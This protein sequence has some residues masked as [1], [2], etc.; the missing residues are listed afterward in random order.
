MKQDS[1]LALQKEND[2]KDNACIDV[3][4]ADTAP[5]EAALGALLADADAD[6]PAADA[7][8]RVRR[9]AERLAQLD[10][11]NVAGMLAAASEGGG[12]GER[13]AVR[14]DA[15]LG[16]AAALAT[17]RTRAARALRA[18]GA[19]DPDA[20]GDPHRTHAD[21]AARRLL[22][23]LRDLLDWL[24][25][26]PLRDLD[27]LGELSLASEEGRARAL[28]VA[29]ALRAALRRAEREP[30]ARR[31]A[32]VRERLRRL[33]RAR[34]QLAAALARHLNNALVH[35]GNEAQAG[36]GRPAAPRRHHAE[37]LPYAPFM[38]WLKDMDSRAFD[39]LGKLYTGTWA[40]VYER[41]VRAASD[42]ARADLAQAPPD[43]VDAIFDGVLGLVETIC[44]AEQEFCT[45][46]FHLDVDVKVSGRSLQLLKFILKLI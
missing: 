38:R 31:L 29:A 15:A 35:L 40:R 25:A 42:A 34:D 17:R 13:L 23:H 46:F 9:L 1:T 30:A 27:A 7:E 32:A 6:E 36:S 41:E 33:A 14:L 16:A 5:S 18:A 12:R 19:A 10:A 8:G 4:D 21:A 24:D 11:A 28:A 44:D 26:P 3:T 45:Q 37:L 20:D 2:A 22:R 39:G 43:R